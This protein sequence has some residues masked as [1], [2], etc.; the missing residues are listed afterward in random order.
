MSPYGPYGLYGTIPKLQ[1]ILV[2][3]HICLGQALCQYLDIFGVGSL[4]E[5][6]EAAGLPSTFVARN[7]RDTSLITGTE[8]C[9]GG[10]T[11]HVTEANKNEFVKLTV[12]FHIRE[13]I[14]RQAALVL[15]ARKA[16]FTPLQ[17]P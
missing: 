10:S 17:G 3:I 1:L 6:L 12:Q 8:L 14:S 16:T 11:V 4:Q 9:V 13:S 2:N 7:C 15:R 5:A